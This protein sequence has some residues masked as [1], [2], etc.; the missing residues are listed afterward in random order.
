MQTRLQLLHSWTSQLQQLL[1]TTR[2]TQVRV[3][4]LFSL[5]LLWAESTTLLR[6]AAR[7]PL[8]V[9]DLST[10]KRLRRWLANAHLDVAPCWDPLA[11]ALVA[12]QGQR[13][14]LLVLDP[15][16]QTQVAT[17]V[18]L[19]LVVQRRALPL[20]WRVLPNQ[21]AWD[22][23]QQAVIAGL[24]QRVAAVLPLGTTV[25]L[26]ADSGLASVDLLDLCGDLGWHYVLRLSVDA[27]Q[28]V[29]VRL[30]D[31]TV[32]PA[33][34]LVR[35]RRQRWF[36]HVQTFKAHGW[37]P[38]D[39]SIVWPARYDQPWVLISDRPAGAAR[40]RE[41]RR[42][43]RIE[44]FFEDCKA[45]GW[46]LERSKLTDRARLDRLL[47]VVALASWWQHLLGAQVIKRGVRRWFDRPGR[48]DLSLA[49][50][51]RRWMG[52]LLDRD[53]LP[54]LPF[55]YCAAGHHWTCRWA[56]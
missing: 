32:C 1:P 34:S 7:L 47:L 24:C 5:G 14:L 27:Q 21:T 46:E 17:V 38:V 13:D 42:R 33:W 19:G 53:H 23:T 56:F 3:L 49:R 41:Y 39:V 29:H 12:R 31:G 43:M 16:T 36:G 37:R 51:G 2:L 40:V 54:P 18:M 26:V 6:I 20:A 44:A 25:T 55:R 28:G 45:R 50:L 8:A 9:Q 52:Y 35:G 30:A 15:T 11:Q 4:A 48:R 10:E 22:T